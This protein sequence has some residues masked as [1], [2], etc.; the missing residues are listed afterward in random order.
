MSD[1]EPLK[2]SIERTRLSAKISDL[3]ANIFMFTFFCIIFALCA[4]KAHALVWGI[5]FMVLFFI[6]FLGWFITAG[7]LYASWKIREEL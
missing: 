6:A 2:V 3:T 7:E 1:A 5:F 4:A